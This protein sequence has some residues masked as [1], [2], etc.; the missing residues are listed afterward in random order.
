VNTHFAFGDDES[1][2][3]VLDTLSSTTATTTASTSTSDD[4][5][6]NASTVDAD[7]DS[8][9]ANT[10]S[11]SPDVSEPSEAPEHVPSNLHL[12]IV[13]SDAIDR[14]LDTY[15]RAAAAVT[16]HVA[17]GTWII[18]YAVRMLLNMSSY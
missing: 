13:G 1:A 10:A 15:R 12:S 7:A 16:R 18:V 9:G 6:T 8:S 3:C 17:N 14:E 2:L 4:S 5:E 11:A